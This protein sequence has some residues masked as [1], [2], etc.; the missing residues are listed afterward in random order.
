MNTATI[1]RKI[2]PRTAALILALVAGS[3][4]AASAG[5]ATPD[6]STASAIVHYGDLNLSTE[7]GIKTLY[8]RIA[9]VAKQVCPDGE[10]RGLENLNHARACQQEAIA[11]A[12]GAVHNERL[13]A[14][15]AAARH[16]G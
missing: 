5:A 2:A 7:Q 9:R 8:Q 4:F 16:H 13:A 15:Y 11:R 14:L 3:G 1:S 10:S 6:E 12:V